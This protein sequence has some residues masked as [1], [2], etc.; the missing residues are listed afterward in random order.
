[1]LTEV[2]PWKWRCVRCGFM[3]GAKKVPW[4]TS[5]VEEHGITVTVL[6]FFHF[7]VTMLTRH[8]K[9]VKFSWSQSLTGLRCVEN[10]STAPC[11]QCINVTGFGK[12]L[13]MGFFLKIAFDVW[14][15]SPTI[16]L[17]RVQVPDR[18]R[19]SLRSYSALFAIAPPPPP[20]IEKLRSKG[21]AMHV[22]G[23]S[24]YYAY[25]GS[26]LN[27]PGWSHSK[28]TQ[29]S[30]E[31]RFSPLISRAATSS[32]PKKLKRLANV[33]YFDESSCT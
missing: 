28:W 31:S 16:E 24:I 27:G 2:L 25:T 14:L 13:R 1:M 11:F 17:T 29:R 26:Q 9:I 3:G 30:S 7:A 19:A 22:Y 15:I 18:S 23:V 32:M 4:A 21:V 33:Q 6:H 12:T 10:D 8:G 20:I 5:K